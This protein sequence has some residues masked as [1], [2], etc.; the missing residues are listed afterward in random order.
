MKESSMKVKRAKNL[1][2]LFELELNFK[3]DKRLKIFFWNLGFA[4]KFDFI[5]F[6]NTVTIKKRNKSCIIIKVPICITGAQLSKTVVRVSTLN[7]SKNSK[8][9]ENCL[10][11]L[12]PNEKRAKNWYYFRLECFK[13]RFWLIKKWRLIQFWKFKPCNISGNN[14]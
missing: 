2:H 11:L 7:S 5:L 13:A 14:C 8:S 4:R 12:S 10:I 3:P 1:E 6:R 9:L